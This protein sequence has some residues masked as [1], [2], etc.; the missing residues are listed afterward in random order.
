MAIDISKPLFIKKESDYV[1]LNRWLEKLFLAFQ[2]LKDDVS[3]IPTYHNKMFGMQGG[4]TTSAGTDERYHLTLAEHTELTEWIDSVILGSSGALT[5]SDAITAG[6]FI[7]NNY[8]NA[9]STSSITWIPATSR[10]ELDSLEATGVIY[11]NNYSSDIA[12]GTSPYACT[13]ETLN[14]HLNADMLDSKHVGTSGNT[15]PLLDGGNTWSGNQIFTDNTKLYFGTGSDFSLSYTGTQMLF[16]PEQA[17]TEI[18]FNEGG[19]DC[20]FRIESDTNPNMF[21]VD[22]GSNQVRIG[23]SSSAFYATSTLLIDSP[24]SSIIELQSTGDSNPTFAMFWN[25]TSPYNGSYCGFFGALNTGAVQG[26]FF[27]F[28]NQFVTAARRNCFE[29]YSDVSNNGWFA[30]K[31]NV[32]GVRSNKISILNNGNLNLLLDN[33]LLTFGAGQDASIY[34]NGTNLIISP[35]DVGTGA[36][37]IGEGA[38]A[39]DYRLMF[40]G[41]TNDGIIDWMEDEDYFKFSDSILLATSEPFYFGDTAIGMYSQADTFLDVFADGGVRVGDSSAGAPT[42]YTKFDADGTISFTGTSGI[43]IPHLMQSDNT[44]QSI[45]DVTE[46]QVITFDT[47]VHHLGITRTSSSRFTITK[48]AS[49]L[50]T[51]SA[52]VSSSVAGKKLVIWMKK[53]G[54]NVDASATYYTFKSANANTIITVTFLY[55]FAVND[56]FELWMY[57]NDTGIKLDYSAAVA[58]SPGVTPAIPA[59]PSIILT[60][61]YVSKD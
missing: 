51:F 21:F 9:E 47:D 5:T 56:Y 2:Q 25:E 27:I 18:V 57:G 6:E 33:Q 4:Q 3:K 12:T 39:V 13:S 54:T 38:S 41:E 58:D 16:S 11:A 36:V 7:S 48:E 35:R 26:G 52:V 20:N 45:T 1:H 30:F 43:I 49:Y 61:N 10:W 28:S 17:T 46:E 32:A 60:C 53:N 42:N 23:T 15:V 31:T 40:N 50:I 19:L 34:Y 59:C 22:A 37:V 14:T 29:M 8:R 44:D 55:H 24:T